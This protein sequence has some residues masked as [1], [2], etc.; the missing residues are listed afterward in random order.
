MTESCSTNS[1][2]LLSSRSS[3]G[4]ALVEDEAVANGLAA[5]ALANGLAA[6]VLLTAAKGDAGVVVDEEEALAKGEAEE[7][8]EKLLGGFALAKMLEPLADAK[9]EAETTR[10]F[11]AAA[12]APLLFD[13]GSSRLLLTAPGENREVGAVA[14]GR[15]VEVL[16]GVG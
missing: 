13:S 4:R 1:D 5:E 3:F 6:D 9:G 16:A 10:P 7:K 2:I 12:G 15:A 8:E 11:G 14:P